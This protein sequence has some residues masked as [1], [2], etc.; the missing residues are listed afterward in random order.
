MLIKIYYQDDCLVVCEKPRGVISQ[1]STKQNMPVL[2]AGQLG[3]RQVHTVHRLDVDTTGVMVY[4][5]NAKARAE[6]SRQVQDHTFK[7]KYITIVEGVPAE[8][9]GRYEDLLFYDRAKQK[10]YIVDRR[11]GGVK[12]RVLDYRVMSTRDGRSTLEIELHTG[13]T[14]QIRAQFASRKMPVL[15]DARYGSKTKTFIHLHCAE[16]SFEHKGK[17]MCFKHTPQWEE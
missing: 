16:I 15:G 7:K 3:V 1:E 14:H 13:R 10:S 12:K 5:L 9:Q 2:L 17:E 6:I 4:A 8:A 11:R